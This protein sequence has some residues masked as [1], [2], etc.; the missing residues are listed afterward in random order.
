MKRGE[1]KDIHSL[2]KIN[3]DDKDSFPDL[4]SLARVQVVE[5]NNIEAKNKYSEVIRSE[6]EKKSV[7]NV[8][9]PKWTY[10]TKSAPFKERVE[11][12]PEERQDI[13]TVHDIIQI[14]INRWKKEKEDYISL[15]GMEDYISVYGNYDYFLEEEDEYDE[16]ESYQEEFYDYTD[17]Y[18]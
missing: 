3:V 16:V 5:T 8:R 11:E 4:A 1:T 2:K 13:H 18:N 9:N 14:M 17:G 7:E 10:L 12:R 6:T 15:Y